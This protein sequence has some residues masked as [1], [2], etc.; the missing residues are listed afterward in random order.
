MWSTEERHGWMFFLLFGGMGL[1]ASRTIL[2]ISLISLTSEM[3]WNRK[4]AL[5]PIFQGLVLGVF[6]WGYALTQF[7]A[8]Y[9]S[10]RLGGER[11]IPCTSFLW[12]TLT[13]SFIYLPIASPRP[14][15]VYG[16]FVCTRFFLGVFQGEATILQSTAVHWQ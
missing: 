9:L 4:E 2:P 3:K 10:D 12:S 13:L 7:L 11:V 1:Y 6:F 15:V 5:F 16:L 8:G 14:D